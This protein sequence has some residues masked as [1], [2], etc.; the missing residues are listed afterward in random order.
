MFYN[1][2]PCVYIIVRV[3]KFLL[4]LLQGTGMKVIL[5]ILSITVF[6][7]ESYAKNVY[8]CEGQAT[9]CVRK[10]EG[11]WRADVCDSGNYIFVFN[12]D[13]SELQYDK[14]IGR[15]NGVEKKSNRVLKM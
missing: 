10:T 14:L 11:L 5:F 7:T 3:K 12:S 15:R 9:M 6:S 4:K 2:C 1:L 13:Y 8:S